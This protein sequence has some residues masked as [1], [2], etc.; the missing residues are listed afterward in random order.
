[1]SYSGRLLA[2]DHGIKRIGLAVSD[3]SWL[4]ARELMV[5]N[6]K[7]RKEDFAL[8]NRIAEEQHAIAIII[9]LPSN[10]DI[11]EEV[12]TQADTV[13]LWVTRFA[14]TTSLPIVLWDEGLSSVD[15]Q[16]LSRQKKRKVTDPVDDLA[17]RVILQSYMDA[18]REG[19]ATPP[20]LP[21][22]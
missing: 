19:L 21:E 9:G 6:R 1:M 12:Y 2:I 10:P 20:K 13:R 15:A 17:A 3:F 7:T 5:I 14:E 18:L 16:E 11:P 22:K 4:I 8:L